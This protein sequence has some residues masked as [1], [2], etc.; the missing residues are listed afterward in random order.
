MLYLL[1]SQI[2]V[3]WETVPGTATADDYS[4]VRG[5]VTLAD[6]VR[7]EFVPLSITDETIPEFSEQFTIQLVGVV[8]GA[9]LGGVTSATVNITASDNPNGALRKFEME[10]GLLLVCSFRM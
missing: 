7:S 8:G 4:P 10:H 5:V 1:V 6:G 9:R 2:I 3:Q